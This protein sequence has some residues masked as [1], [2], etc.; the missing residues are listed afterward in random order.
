MEQTE[1]ITKI[2]NLQKIAIENNILLKY[3]EIGTAIFVE[4][5]KVD[6]FEFRIISEKLI[7]SDFGKELE[8]LRKKIN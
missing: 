3:K 8:I 1:F 2:E 5:I 6:K 7:L 4:L